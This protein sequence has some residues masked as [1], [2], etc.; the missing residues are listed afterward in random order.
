MIAHDLAQ[1]I[2]AINALVSAALRA[3]R[4][5]ASDQDKLVDNLTKI[6][7]E[8]RR[9]SDAIRAFA[10]F[11][12]DGASDVGTTELD[13]VLAGAL[14]RLDDD[15]RRHGITVR[16]DIT[17][18]LPS[19]AVGPAAVGQI[20]A[21][22]LRNAIDA[23]TRGTGERREISIAA[24]PSHDGMIEVSVADTGPGIDPEFARTIF[25]PFAPERPREW[26]IGLAVTRTIIE[27]LGGR[28]GVKSNSGEGAVVAF[29]LPP[30]E[31]EI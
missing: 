17:P 21:C 2:T 4:A 9:A 16:L 5:P 28:I 7:R 19:V 26:G 30:A 14:A 29:M 18:G 25:D 8:A 1:P 31:K 6:E 20:S 23:V 27:A 12:H 3:A 24:A 13:V 11:A 22:L 15:V 10:Q